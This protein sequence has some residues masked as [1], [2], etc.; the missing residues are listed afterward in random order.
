MRNRSS[1]C[2]RVCCENATYN[3]AL[4]TCESCVN[5]PV[6]QNAP[7]ADSSE[8]RT[9]TYFQWKKV[10]IKETQT[11][12]GESV[13]RKVT[14]GKQMADNL[15]SVMALYEESLYDVMGHLF[16]VNH[17]YKAIISAK[18]SLTDNDAIG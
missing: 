10:V 18:E 8:S 13:Q 7:S 11:A 2:S 17:Q 9:I 1:L 6:F 4:H 15:S 16:R 5:R 12:D 3:Y 14:R